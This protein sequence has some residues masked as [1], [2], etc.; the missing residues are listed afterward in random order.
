MN[1][2]INLLIYISEYWNIYYLSR[3]G[4]GTVPMVFLLFYFCKTNLV[5]MRFVNTYIWYHTLLESASEKIFQCKTTF[6]VIIMT[7][8]YVPYQHT[9]LFSFVLSKRRDLDC[10]VPVPYRYYTIR[11]HKVHFLISKIYGLWKISWK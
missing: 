10:W 2:K 9:L 11:Y 7:T 8:C 1:C 5:T 3:Y 6:F 4:T